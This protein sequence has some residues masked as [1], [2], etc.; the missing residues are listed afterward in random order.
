MKRVT[1][2]QRLEGVP[3]PDEPFVADWRSWDITA[4][5][6]KTV[7]ALPK[8]CRAVSL[9]GGQNWKTLTKCERAA[10]RQNIRIIWLSEVNQSVLA[11]CHGQD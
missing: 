6:V 4:T 10:R 3:W 11:R 8:N 5:L 7:K 9:R 2:R 1:M